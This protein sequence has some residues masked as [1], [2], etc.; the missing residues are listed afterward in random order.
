M[1]PFFSAL[2]TLVAQH[3]ERLRPELVR[4]LERNKSAAEV[5]QREG[6]EATETSKRAPQRVRAA[7]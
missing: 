3:G 1:I 6:N 7:A 5:C 2:H 4:L